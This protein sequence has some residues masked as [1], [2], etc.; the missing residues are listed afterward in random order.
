[1]KPLRGWAGALMLAALTSCSGSGVPP[2]EA[3]V[4]RAVPEVGVARIEQ[5]QL[6]AFA[7]LALAC[8]DRPYPYKPH[9]VLTSDASLALP[10]EL[11]PTFYG[12]FDW[13]SAVHAH[14]MLLR[15]VKTYPELP[16]AQRVRSRLDPHMA[17]EPLAR[18]AAYF[19]E[20]GRRAFER[21]YGWAWLLR[22]AAEVRTWPDGRGRGWAFN[23]V[24]LETEIVGRLREYLQRLD[25]PIRSGTHSNTAFAL[26]QALDYADA[27][28]DDGLR[29]LVAERA[30]DYY[31]EDQSCPVNY[32]PGGEDFFS[33]CLLEADL[34]R[35]VLSAEEFSA[36]IDGFLPGLR[37]G[38]LGPV[39]APARVSDP[40]DPKIAHL[41]GL[42]LVRAW[43]LAG[44]AAALPEG[45]PRRT[46]AA[47][48]ADLHARTG[49]AGVLSG[50]YEGE[51]WLASFAVYLVTGTGLG[52]AP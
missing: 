1:M 25:W 52:E 15:L 48:L 28:G 10:R 13:H 16:V 34:M 3:H 12:C 40:S 17:R 50:H 6:V 29:R 42:N 39:E 2:E 22:L 46:H 27:V 41:D 19:R 32:E 21:P 23:L 51:H 38:E 45:D 18:E 4:P 20:K 8:I 37:H 44:I 43:C 35:R 31:I 7:E 30:R 24:P 9:H 14:W 26:A 36:W 5:E 33:P 47:A 11:H 49:L